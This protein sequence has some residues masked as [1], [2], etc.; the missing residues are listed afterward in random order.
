[1][2]VGSV[3]Y[4]YIPQ[5]WSQ[6][7]F[8]ALGGYTVVFLNYN[9][10]AFI[11]QSVRAALAQDFPALEMFFMDDASTDGSGDEMEQIV[12][13]YRGRHKVTVIRNTENQR[14][15]GQWNIVARLATGHWLGMF[16]GDDIAYPN[17]VTLT[18]EI[19]R[20]SPGV[21]GVSTSGIEVNY[22]SGQTDVEIGRG[23]E[24][25]DVNADD[26]SEKLALRWLVVVGATAFWHRSLF[27][28]PLPT[29][30]M[31]DEIL[32]YRLLVRRESCNGAVYRFASKTKTIR[33]AIGTGISTEGRARNSVIDSRRV[34]WVKAIEAIKH[35]HR[36]LLK[37]WRG[38]YESDDYREASEG[39]QGLLQM[40]L[41][42]SEIVVGSTITRLKLLPRLI[43]AI[44]QKS[45]SFEMKM[46]LVR[47]WAK[48]LLQEFLGVRLMSFVVSK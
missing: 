46:R 6:E 4:T 28:T 5:D 43:K 24:P 16:C 30:P 7:T 25:F 29:G 26:V 10:K 35:Q 48:K 33:Y 27:D 15:T 47:L 40:R 23:I 21:L 41:L 14:I 42:Y 2:A 39:M 13:A 34:R 45:M 12:R 31:D 22:I 36:V 19:L 20:E 9:K 18:D 3:V 44:V 1:M 8:L 38:I 11:Q 32:F 17:R 37:T